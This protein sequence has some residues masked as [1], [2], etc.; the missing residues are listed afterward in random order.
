MPLSI[1]T[2]N[3]KDL[4]DAHD[5][6]AQEPHVQDGSEPDSW[7]TRA[8]LD[9]KLDVLSALLTRMD[10]DV[11]GLQEVGS[12]RVLHELCDR[13]ERRGGYGEPIVGTRD[14]RGIGN[15]VLARVPVVASR[16]L[17]PPCLEFPVF[18]E[19]DPPP[20]GGRIPM[21]RGVVNPTIDGGALGLIDVFVVHFKSNRR[22]PMRDAN[23]TLGPRS[24]NVPSRVLA[25]GELRSLVWRASEALFVR[26]LVDEVLAQSAEAKVAVLGDL[27]DRPG[28]LVVRTVMGWGPGGL[29]SAAEAIEEPRRFSIIHRGKPDLFDYVLL[30]E[31][32]GVRTLSAHLYNEKLRDH[33]ELVPDPQGHTPEN[34]VRLAPTPDSDH[35]PLVVRFS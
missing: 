21:R 6:R 8:E 35:A 9:A 20:F 7:M 16:V 32:L 11:L 29:R 17:T 34:T 15:A 27:N 13:L 3:V 28:S 1:G 10:A 2:F 30:T 12:T 18:Q 24:E 23:G 5:P 25:E 14:A 33:G 31:N 4:F 22:V 19:G 26:G